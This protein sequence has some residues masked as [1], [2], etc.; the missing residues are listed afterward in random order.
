MRSRNRSL[1]RGQ[2]CPAADAVKGGSGEPVPHQ[3]QPQSTA[4]APTEGV[5]NMQGHAEAPR[6]GAVRREF[7]DEVAG[8]VPPIRLQ[9]LALAPLAWLARRRGHARALRAVARHRL[10]QRAER[11]RASPPAGGLVR[12]QKYRYGD[13]KTDPARTKRRTITGTDGVTLTFQQLAGPSGPVERL[14]LGHAPSSS[15]CRSI[16]A[17]SSAP[18][19]MATSVSHSQLDQ[20][21]G[22]G[23]GAV[24]SADVG[25]AR[26]YRGKRPRTPRAR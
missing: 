1:E 24:D 21:D 16:S 10:R 9:H 18:N 11:L 25:N 23:E 6:P 12:M 3:V 17:L 8:P 15:C 4:R 14:C 7:K 26:A 20:H 2:N 13:S 5:V 22:S 19:S